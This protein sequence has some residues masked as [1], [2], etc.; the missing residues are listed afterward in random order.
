MIMRSLVHRWLGFS[1]P[2]GQRRRPVV[3]LKHKEVFPRCGGASL[4]DPMPRARECVV[5]G[6]GPQLQHLERGG[7]NKWRGQQSNN[8]WSSTSISANPNNAWIVNFNNGNT[9]NDNKTNS[10]YVRAVRGGS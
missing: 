2:I 3:G 7:G 4:P 9:N 6:C 8:Y 5:A 10:Y 1:L